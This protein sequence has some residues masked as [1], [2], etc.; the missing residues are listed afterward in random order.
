HRNMVVDLMVFDTMNPRSI[1]YLL[2]RMRSL[3]ALLPGA[4]I[5]GVMSPLARAVLRA[6]AAIAVETPETVDKA[7]L[8]AL[9]ERLEGLSDLLS[10]AY[11]T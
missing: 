5:H 2:E 10:E 6:H 11:L 9:G 8:T 3:I 7:A 1:L 4:E